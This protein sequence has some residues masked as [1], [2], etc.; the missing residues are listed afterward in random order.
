MNDQYAIG[1]DLGGTTVK[2]GLVSA[3]GSIKYQTKYPSNAQLRQNDVLT[4]IETAVRDVMD[5]SQ[6]ASIRGIGIGSPGVV[7]DEGVVKAP[8]NFVDFDQVP[9]KAKIESVFRVPTVAE[10]DANVAAIAES[11]FGAG[12]KYKDFLFVIW[13]TGVGGGIIL[14]NQIYRGPFG[15]AGEI[16]HISVDYKGPQCNCGSIGCVEAFVG[17]KY[18]SQRTVERLKNHPDSRILKLVGGN[19][20][21]IEPVYISEAAKAGDPLAREM[22]LEA[23]MLLG[24]ALGA[25]MNTMDLRISIIG[26]GISAAG[27]FVMDAIKKSVQKHV[28]KPLRPD[29]QVLPAKLG[30]DAGILGAAGLVL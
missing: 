1:V 5:H 21:K 10:N 25:V 15:G 9:L 6:G 11:K 12:K 29:I 8:P 27:D 16:G 3:A 7:D 4:Q 13:G 26:G 2:A 17:Q 22:L 30:N 20:D 19:P 28:L 24:V 14:N 18:L 23:G